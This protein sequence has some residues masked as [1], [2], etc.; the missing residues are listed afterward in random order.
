MV[1]PSYDD[2]LVMAEATEPR[3]GAAPCGHPGQVGGGRGGVAPP[4]SPDPGSGAPPDTADQN[5]VRFV[6]TAVKAKRLPG[7]LPV[8]KGETAMK[9]PVGSRSASVRRVEASTTRPMPQTTD[10]VRKCGARAAGR[11]AGRRRTP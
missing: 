1:L 6:E 4:G 10:S 5:C 11:A 3:I 9:V 7:T 8:M 2:D